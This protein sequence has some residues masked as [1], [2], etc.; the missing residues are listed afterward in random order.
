M[1]YDYTT[2]EQKAASAQRAGLEVVVRHHDDMSGRQAKGLAD[3]VRNSF[4][5]NNKSLSWTSW[6]MALN[7]ARGQHVEFYHMSSYYKSGVLD[8]IDTR[9]HGYQLQYGNWESAGRAAA[10][11]QALININEW[12]HHMQSNPRV[13]LRD[14]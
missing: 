3:V 2:T 14:F 5:N 10:R 13:T 8:F 1:D 11:L 12:E 7:Y 4:L 9:H 6:H